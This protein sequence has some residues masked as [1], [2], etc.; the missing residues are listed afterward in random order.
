MEQVP[1]VWPSLDTMHMETLG[2]ESD[3]KEVGWLEPPGGKR[4]K[5][6][7]MQ[8]DRMSEEVSGT[9]AGNVSLPGLTVGDP[10]GYARA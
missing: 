4:S 6:Q 8:A 3:A 7:M 10:E 5:Y 2:R 9:H 1:L